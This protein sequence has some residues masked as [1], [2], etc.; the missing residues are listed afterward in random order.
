MIH[1][2]SPADWVNLIDSQVPDI[3]AL[4]IASWDA[5]PAPAANELENSITN[6]LCARM[7]NAPNRET[8][9]FHIQ[10]QDVI[11][12]PGTGDEL[13]RTDIAFK[14]F[15]PS[16]K[17]YFCLECKRLNVRIPN[18]PRPRP[19]FSEYVRNG[20][21]R[22]I[23]G[24]NAGAVRN[25]GML[26]LVLDADLNAA[27]VGVQGNIQ[28][29][30]AELGMSSPA[31][32]APSSVQPADT[33]IRETNHRRAHNTEPF[34]IHHLFMAGD[35]DAPFLPEPHPKPGKTPRKPRKSRKSTKS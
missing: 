34:T 24:Q 30:Q 27:M 6:R 13:G 18:A 29:A 32:F 9:P 3:L 33:R 16:D 26:A 7:Q 1:F 23:S 25:G 4:V 19:Y 31:S 2:G 5:L 20:M 35:P 17:I 28:A 8:F 15:V 10:P 21:L 14:P 11:L 22:F 12:E